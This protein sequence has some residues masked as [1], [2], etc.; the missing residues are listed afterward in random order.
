M[1][2]R[3]V[4]IKQVKSD[5]IEGILLG[6][7]ELFRM[8]CIYK[9]ITLENNLLI[10]GIIKIS[11]PEKENDA[12]E[13]L[14]N[15]KEVDGV[16][17]VPLLTSPSLMKSSESLEDIKLEA[18]YFF[19]N[20]SDKDFKRI[21]ESVASL[22]KI[23]GK[24]DTE[25]CINKDI[26]AR[27]GL[28][29]S[30]SQSVPIDNYKY[31][32][33]PEK[34]YDY[35]AN[36]L[37][38]AD[39]DK[40]NENG[41]V[42][43]D[44]EG[45]P[46]KEIDLSKIHEPMV[47]HPN[48]TVKHTM[49]DGC[50]YMMPSFAKRLEESMGLDYKLDFCIVRQLGMATKGLLVSFDW[51]YYLEEE[52]AITA[53]EVK[54]FWGNEVN[55]FDM[56]VVM[57]A[58]QVKWCKWFTSR[59]E[60][61]TRK[62]MIPKYASIL[63]AIAITKTNKEALEEYFSSNYQINSN[64]ALS[65]EELNTLGAYTEELYKKISNRDV[66]TIRLMLGDIAKTELLEEV[67]ASTKA[68]KLI[69]IRE[70][71]INTS[72]SRQIVEALINKKVNQ[73]AGGKMLLKGNYKMVCQD[74]LSYFDKIAFDENINGLKPKTIYVHGE[75][76]NRTLARCPLNN[77]TEIIKTTISDSN[78]HKKYIDVTNEIIFIALDNNAMVASGLDEDG[79]IIAT[80]DEKLI[81]DSVIEDIID[82]QVYN[83][84]NQ[85][86]GG[87]TEVKFDKEGINLID[88]IVETRGNVIGELSNVG[89][90][91]SNIVQG[92]FYLVE[93]EYFT[94]KEV[95][96][97]WLDTMKKKKKEEVI[98]ILD[99]IEYFGE[100]I[101]AWKESVKYE[102]E[103]QT[104]DSGEIVNAKEVIEDWKDRLSNFKKKLDAMFV[105]GLEKQIEKGNIVDCYTLEES[106]RKNV[107]KYAFNHYKNLQY[108]TTYLQMVAIDSV[109]TCVPV[110]REQKKIIEDYKKMAIPVYV[111]YAK[112][113]KK[114]KLDKDRSYNS[115]PSLLND[116]SKK[117]IKEIGYKARQDG[118]TDFKKLKD[119][120]FINDITNKELPRNMELNQKLKDFIKKYEEL[121]AEVPENIPKEERDKQ[122]DL[123]DITLQL[124]FNEDIV[125]KYSIQEILNEFPKV[126]IAKISSKG[127]GY[128]YKVNARQ[129]CRFA[130]EQVVELLTGNE[131]YKTTMYELCEN[132]K[133]EFKHKKYDKVDAI[134]SKDSL[135]EVETYRKVKNLGGSETR[136]M[137]LTEIT[138]KENELIT[139]TNKDVIASDGK[140]IGKEVVNDKSEVIGLIPTDKMID[141]G[142][143]RIVVITPTKTGKSFGLNL[144]AS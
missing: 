90:T 46:V 72:F 104:L 8:Y 40:L 62:A 58:S 52:Y 70:K 76:G 133:Y 117:V 34:T 9:N 39:K 61:D 109:K 81:Y 75:T 102:G 119:I 140:V 139:L 2:I 130:F 23:T 82:G 19:I 114:P 113:T 48:M 1:G 110:T 41:E 7:N 56:D 68:H 112:Y 91:L 79:D 4:K 44:K 26:V 144:L 141:E 116:Y 120:A 67:T 87:T 121:R 136:I 11:L 53:L 123:I 134:I 25:L 122:F 13:L 57:N 93:T 6:E 27:L 59:N 96:D 101:R 142:K 38:F 95:K 16:K 37:Q 80:I 89:A 99:K 14:L 49:A 32:V 45:K 17:Y 131:E 5:K 15:G 64:L 50:G 129:M 66:D 126:E 22:D 12:R 63:N 24:Y 29:T 124:E 97:L 98:S 125:S 132:G 128:I 35:V 84:R 100:Q 71:F 60:I 43:L 103:I 107:I 108:Y 18:D 78:K 36:Y 10:D 115:Y 143:Y 73:L 106:E 74:P 111:G 118:E 30:T 138:F 94:R 86:D 135:T 88:A 85:F 83:F 65:K 28:L 20:E 137:R 105:K 51:K 33:L 55:L 31:C 54:D 21:M 42:V 127:N 77:P 69:Q 3:M 47:K 92:Q